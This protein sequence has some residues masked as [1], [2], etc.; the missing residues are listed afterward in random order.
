MVRT[1]L[2]GHFCPLRPFSSRIPYFSCA[3]TRRRRNI[4][5]DTRSTEG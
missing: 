2:D 5:E 4:R 1:N 3:G